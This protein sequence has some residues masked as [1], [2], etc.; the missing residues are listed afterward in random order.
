MAAYSDI[1]YE[2][3]V[4]RTEARTMASDILYNLP[5]VGFWVKDKN[6]VWF[7]IS[8]EAS[9]IL[10]WLDSDECIWKTDL[11]L[12]RSS[13]KIETP[14]QYCNVCRS[15]DEYVLNNPHWK[16]YYN[17]KFVEIIKWIDWKKHIWQVT[18]W[19]H[20]SKVGEVDYYHYWVAVF[21]D[22]LLWI[23]WANKWLEEEKS[24]LDKI[25]DNLYV[26]KNRW[27]K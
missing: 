6:F 3:I 15:S 7:D 11:E 27:F 26:Y 1:D 19:I 4:K 12:V 21:K 24:A 5:T 14:D 20:P 16:E 2:D 9:N 10:Y 25:N 22:E 8:E 17:Y 13:W 18:K 23:K